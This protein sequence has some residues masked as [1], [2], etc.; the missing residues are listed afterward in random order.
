MGRLEQLLQAA[1]Q[2]NEG[3]SSIHSSCRLTL[4]FITSSNK[5]IAHLDNMRHAL[6]LLLQI[7]G[8]GNAPSPQL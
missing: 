2:N 1:A 6:A 3:R 8:K 7:D 5:Q 4:S